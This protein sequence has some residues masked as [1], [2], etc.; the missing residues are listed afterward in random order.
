M[1]ISMHRHRKTFWLSLTALLTSQILFL[2]SAQASPNPERGKSLIQEK[3][4]LTCH[5][6][7]DTL[8]NA[9]PLAGL[10][11]RQ[12]RIVEDGVTRDI[13]ADEAYIK[14]SILHPVVEV[15]EGFLPGSMPH[16]PISEQDADD[17]TAAIMSY[18]S[19]GVFRPPVPIWCLLGSAF[20][21]VALHL[22][23]SSHPIRSR[24]IKKLS[25][26]G[27]QG[28]YSLLVLSAFVMVIITFRSAP[29]IGLWQSPKWTRYFPN[30]VM[31]ISF[32]LLVLSMTTKNPTTAGQESA[33]SAEPA[34]IVKVTR[35]PMLWGILLWGLAHLP[36]NGD[37]RSAILFGSLSVLSLLGMLHIDARRKRA[38]GD[39][40]TAFAS[41]TS[42]IPFGA[43]LSGRAKVGLLEIGIGKI[44]IGLLM[45]AIM[46]MAHKSIFGL[47]ALP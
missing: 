19:P 26:K 37:A 25:D 11:G 22:G 32:V 4:C 7:D 40:W 28:L 30:V 18:R 17:M 20:L 6:V 44:L 21:F 43:I 16:F 13:I 33:A 39:A 9:P 36:P 46:I 10:A 14:R 2:C 34:G 8:R 27:F 47:S 31:P 24:L 42:L 12:R 45:Y 15:V 23:L 3:S 1:K 35:H 41:K 38:L 29:Y 5:S